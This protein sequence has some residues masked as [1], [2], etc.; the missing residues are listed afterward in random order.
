MGYSVHEWFDDYLVPR[1]KEVMDNVEKNKKDDEAIDSE[2]YKFSY[3]LFIGAIKEALREHNDERFTSQMFSMML[4]PEDENMDIGDAIKAAFY[5]LTA[6]NNETVLSKL[7][8]RK[9]GSTTVVVNYQDYEKES[10]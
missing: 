4:N 7:E 10:E 3:D 9:D 6:W 5:K 8:Y 2:N 1:L